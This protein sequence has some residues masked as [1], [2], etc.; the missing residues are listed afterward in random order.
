MRFLVCSKSCFGPRV[1]LPRPRRGANGRGAREA[2]AII[3]AANQFSQAQ[4]RGQAQNTATENRDCS[5][6]DGIS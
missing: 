4:A 3:G 6:R 1:P 5:A 2:F